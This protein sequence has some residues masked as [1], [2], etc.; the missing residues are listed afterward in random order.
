MYM[1]EE[2]VSI[3]GGQVYFQ[4]VVPLYPDSPLI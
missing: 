2:I 3:E 4:G 1:K